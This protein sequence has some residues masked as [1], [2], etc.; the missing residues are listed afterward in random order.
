MLLTKVAKMDIPTTHDGILPPPA[1]N[2]SDVRFLEKKL[3]PRSTFP[4]V[5][6]TKTSRSRK[7]SFIVELQVL[8]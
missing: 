6:T 5:R 4:K 3:A 8:R 2:W 7:G 1:V